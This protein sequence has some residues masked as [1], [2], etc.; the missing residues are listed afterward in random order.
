MKTRLFLLTAAVL[1]WAQNG[2]A[3][4]PP[5][6]RVRGTIVSRAG[7]PIAAGR[8]QTDA[9]AGPSGSQFVGQRRFTATAGAK[10]EWAILGVTR[11]TWIFE[12]SAAGYAPGVVAVTVNLTGDPNRPVTWELP[13]HLVSLDELRAAGG[14]GKALANDL[15][16][17]VTAGRFPTKEDV[18]RILARK[19]DTPFEGISLCAVGNLALLARDL[20]TAF[21]TFNR[22]GPA[23]ACGA[24]GLASVGLL[25]ADYDAA[26]AAYDAARKATRDEKLQRVISAVLADLRR[27]IRPLTP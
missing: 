5:T 17:A 26:L 25:S 18:L 22:V 20:T 2:S 27:V 8:V 10:G 12:A 9:I 14:S 19:R 16:P 21:A 13:L 4:D 23:E 3:Q 1:A 6:V 11:G 7:H 15:A 24:L